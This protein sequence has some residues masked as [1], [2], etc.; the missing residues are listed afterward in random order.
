MAGS[1]E[2]ANFDIFTVFKSDTDSVIRRSFHPT[3]YNELFLAF[4]FIAQLKLSI[5]R[6]IKSDKVTAL[7]T[8]AK[9][10]RCL[11]N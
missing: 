6:C 10:Y 1:S 7:C 3:K 8:P 4:C 9:R 5:R 2:P 11:I